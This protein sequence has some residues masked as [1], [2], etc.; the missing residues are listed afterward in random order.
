[1]YNEMFNIK[2][3]ENILTKYKDVVVQ[4]SSTEIMSTRRGQGRSETPGPPG[5]HYFCAVQ[6]VSACFRL[7]EIESSGDQ[8]HLRG[9]D[10]I[11]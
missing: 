6:P 1:M 9:N 11:G 3:T 8:E 10:L 5:L 2:I 4:H 7:N